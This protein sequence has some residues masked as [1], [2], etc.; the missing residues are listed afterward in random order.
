MIKLFTSNKFGYYQRK[1]VI[2]QRKVVYIRGLTVI[3]CGPPGR[4]WAG[5]V[6]IKSQNIAKPPTGHFIK[7]DQDG[8][9]YEIDYNPLRE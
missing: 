3:P 1:D 8:Q 6:W 4:K 7:H 9:L 2:Y 5:V